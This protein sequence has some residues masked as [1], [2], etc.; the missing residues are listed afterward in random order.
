MNTE[1]LDCFDSAEGADPRARLARLQAAMEA[2]P[3]TYEPALSHYRARGLYG[4]RIYVPAGHCVATRVHRQVHFTIALKGHCR[5]VDQ[6]GNLADVVAP[7]VF[8]TQP[9]TQRAC[10]ALSDVEWLTVHAADIADVS[11][12]VGLLTCGSMAEYAA[13]KVENSA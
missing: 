1:I 4:R 8:V 11:T 12:A 6:D 13:C 10:L 9:G 3:E 5:V 7:A 2:L